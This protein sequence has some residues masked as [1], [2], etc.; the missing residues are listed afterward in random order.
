[1]DV[2]TAGEIVDAIIKDL[3]GRKG[4]RQE[5]EQIDPGIQNEIRERWVAI[6]MEKSRE[7]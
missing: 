1:M 6:V 7:S 5:F 3:T 2:I 4:L